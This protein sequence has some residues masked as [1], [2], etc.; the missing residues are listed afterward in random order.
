MLGPVALFSRV[1]AKIGLPIKDSK[2]V[3]PCTDI[4]VH[5]LQ[6]NSATMISSLPADKI[7]KA[8]TQ[9][10]NLSHKK[11]I[12]LLALQSICGLLNFA[13]KAVVPGA[14]F[15]MQNDKFSYWIEQTISLRQGQSRSARR[16][17]GTDNVPSK[18]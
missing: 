16:C 7:N 4:S 9:L 2:T 8:I 10:L 11:K 6:I 14:A 12:S 18:L 17:A 1:I 5:G 13:C 15:F 3:Y